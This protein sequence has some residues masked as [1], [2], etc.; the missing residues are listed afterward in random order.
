MTHPAPAPGTRVQIRPGATSAWGR[1]FPDGGRATVLDLDP[2]EYH[3]EHVYVLPDGDPEHNTLC[4]RVEDLTPI[5]PALPVD[6]VGGIIAPQPLFGRDEPELLVPLHPDPDTVDDLGDDE[7]GT[8]RGTTV[9]MSAV[10]LTPFIE[11]AT[12]AF[13]AEAGVPFDAMSQYDQELARRCQRAALTAVTAVLAIDNPFTNHYPAPRDAG[14]ARYGSG[15][16]GCSCHDKLMG[17]RAH[18]LI[19]VLRTTLLGETP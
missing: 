2:P 19:T 4:L 15:K 18:H 16:D 12:R 11:H 10:V 7:L 8:F 6:E 17:G 13:Y 9:A 14:D 1:E 5:A 3:P